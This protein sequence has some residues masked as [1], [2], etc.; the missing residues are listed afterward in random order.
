MTIRSITVADAIRIAALR[1]PD[2]VINPWGAASGGRRLFSP[3]RFLSE[4]LRPR[5]RGAAWVTGNGLKGTA[6]ASAK[7]R[8]G[9]TAWIM[10]HLV[11]PRYDVGPCCELL[12]EVAIH[13]GHRGAERL[14]LQLLDDDQLVDMARSSG[15][16]PCAQVLL[17]TL[18]GQGTLLDM[19]SV[20]GLRKRE[21]SDDLSL[22]RLYSATTPADVRSG[23]GATLVQWKDAQEPLRRSTQELVLEER[24]GIKGWLRLDLHRKWA[25]ARLSIQPGWEGDIIALVALAQKESESRILCWEVPESDG[26]L[27]LVLER[28]GFEATGSYWL[29]IKLLAVRVKELLLA[30]APTSG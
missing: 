24:D 28:A 17:F 6:L 23:I 3:A 26:T 2:W 27:R 16:V 9:P 19:T 8:A 4:Y 11:T 20:A 5:P 7:P 25:T 29:F 18:S 15:F 12:E 14:F 22:F 21:P 1:G 13:A 30:T 10:D